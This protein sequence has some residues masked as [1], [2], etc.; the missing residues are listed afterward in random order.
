M[1]DG[2]ILGYPS[3]NGQRK[4]I[5]AINLRLNGDLASSYNIF[6][7]VHCQS[8]GWLGWAKNGENAGTLG[9]SYRVEAIKIRL[10]KKNH[11]SPAEDSTKNAFCSK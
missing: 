9:Y 7:K 10:V 8:L 11:T 6:Y 2:R 3:A 4:R 5:E 1:A